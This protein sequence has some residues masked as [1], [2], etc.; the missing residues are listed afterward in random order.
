MKLKNVLIAVN[1]VEQSRQFYSDLFGLDLDRQPAGGDFSLC[2]IEN[3]S[4]NDGGD[5][6]N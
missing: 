6:G 3:G 1:D 5:K 4:R 2:G